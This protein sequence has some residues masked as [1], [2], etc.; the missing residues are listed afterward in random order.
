MW[1]KIRPN[2]VWAMTLMALLGIIISYMGWRMGNEGIMSAA[3][4]GALV[5]ISNLGAK[6]LEKE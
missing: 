4:V 1:N 2:I 6:I 5:G 3:G